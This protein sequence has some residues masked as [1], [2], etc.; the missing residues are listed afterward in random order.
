MSTATDLAERY[1][2]PSAWHRRTVIGAAATVSAAFLVW[3]GWVAWV[4]INP[5]VTSELVGFTVVD[6]HTVNATVQFKIEDESV[7]PTCTLR[8]YA[9]DKVVV[10]ELVFTP[11]GEGRSSYDIRTERLATSVDM[12]GCTAPGQNRPR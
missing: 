1:G 7:E 11:E 3:L 8:A 10:G 12:L 2:A 4:Q 6:E 9:E 5:E